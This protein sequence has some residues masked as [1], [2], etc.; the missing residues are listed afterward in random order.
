MFFIHL[1]SFIPHLGFIEKIEEGFPD[2]VYRNGLIYHQVPFPEPTLDLFINNWR[3]DLVILKNQKVW[4]NDFH[5]KTLFTQPHKFIQKGKMDLPANILDDFIELFLSGYNKGLKG[6]EKELGITYVSLPIEDKLSTL[7]QL[8]EDNLHHV[9]FNGRSDPEYVFALGY[10]QACLVLASKEYNIY[11]PLVKEEPEKIIS[12]DKRTHWGQANEQSGADRDQVY[13]IPLYHSLEEIVTIWLSLLDFHESAYFR[14]SSYY[15]SGI[16]IIKV[17]GMM[18][19]NPSAENE[20]ILPD[21]APILQQLPPG[22]YKKLLN[23]LMHV[24]YRLNQASGTEKITLDKYGEVLKRT[25]SC[26]SDIAVENLV[27]DF[28]RHTKKTSEALKKLSSNTYGHRAYQA[29]KKIRG[30]SS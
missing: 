30:Y 17:L 4:V 26:Y 29:L 11:R 3:F 6:F 13:K 10:V 21:V 8:V 5:L 19:R 2:I 16:E 20:A 25:F 24:T 9:R 28:T 7:L 18:F 23:L 22:D 15:K 14:T 27:K 1:P 12:K